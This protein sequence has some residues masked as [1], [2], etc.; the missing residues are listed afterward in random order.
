MRRKK[1]LLFNVGDKVKS[2]NGLSEFLITGFGLRNKNDKEKVFYE[3]MCLKCGERYRRNANHVKGNGCANCNKIKSNIPNNVP[4]MI[5]YFQGGYEEAKKYNKCSNKK[6][7][8]VCP[9][10][11]K[12][13][14]RLLAIN[15]LYNYGLK[16]SYCSIGWTFPERFIMSLLNQLGVDYICQHTTTDLC[17]IGDFKRYDFYLPYYHVIIETH[18]L[19]HYETPKHWG[20]GYSEK[21]NDEY[22]KQLAILNGIKYYVEL[23]CR[24]SNMKWIKSS[25]MNS[26]LPSILNFT[27]Y[28][29]DWIKCSKY[30][31][32]DRIK[33]I[34]NDYT[35]YF[36]TTKQ[37]C[38]KYHLAECTLLSYLNIGTLHGWCVHSKSINTYRKP[39]EVLKNGKH[40]GY[41]SGVIDASKRFKND[42]G[43]YFH[44]NR[45]SAALK[46]GTLYKGYEIRYVE[47]IQL[48]WK[49]LKGEVA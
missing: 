31:N 7:Y 11:G 26:V 49:I 41:Y 10:C 32:E 48:K 37:L 1:C 23:D 3:C 27:E 12:V 38:E 45:A 18:G 6:I 34:C 29:V 2:K 46:N 22:K 42:T 20:K 47:D 8:P 17:F 40:I 36:L 5:P 44:A 16:C 33:E 21:D 19:Q 14:N 4:W 15:S 28:D 39:I 25:V 9:I 35:N 30:S 24:N 13:Q 43:E